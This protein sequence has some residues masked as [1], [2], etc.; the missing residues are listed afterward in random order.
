MFSITQIF[1]VAALYAFTGFIIA[2]R[3]QQRK[4]DRLQ[5]TLA[6]KE[7][8]ERLTKVLNA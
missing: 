5:E 8:M 7:A 1:I 4:I 6:G 3:W 2:W